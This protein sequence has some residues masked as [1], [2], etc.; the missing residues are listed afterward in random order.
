MK[1]F[2]R[3]YKITM[4]LTIALAAIVVIT[5]S[6]LAAEEIQD[7]MIRDLSVLFPNAPRPLVHETIHFLNHNRLLVVTDQLTIVDLGT[8]EKVAEIPN[9]IPNNESFD[10]SVLDRAQ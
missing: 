9:P 3:L 4:L 1:P 8:M 7:S 2:K 6:A 5:F 10:F